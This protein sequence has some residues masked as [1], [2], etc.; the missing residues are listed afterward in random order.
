M[1]RRPNAVS[2]TDTADAQGYDAASYQHLAIDGYYSEPVVATFQQVGRY[3]LP[4][5]SVS[6]QNNGGMLLHDGVGDLDSRPNV[7]MP[8]WSAPGGGRSVNQTG[9]MVQNPM[10]SYNA[11][12]QQANAFSAN[13]DET[14]AIAQFL[15]SR[16]PRY[17]GMSALSG[18]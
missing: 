7:F 17:A 18:E 6:N 8:I 10:G 15:N 9:G 16:S 14:S 5:A 3:R 13:A 2:G 1:R 12:Q 4:L 11:G